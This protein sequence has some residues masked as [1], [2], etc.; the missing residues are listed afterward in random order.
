MVYLNNLYRANLYN[1]ENRGAKAPQKN[2]L[3]FNRI[4]KNTI[5]SLNEVEYFWGNINHFLRYLKLYKLLK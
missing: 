3:N 1:T 4:K 5:Q 2:K